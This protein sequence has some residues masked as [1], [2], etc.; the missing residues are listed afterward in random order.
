[1]YMYTRIHTNVYTCIHTCTHKRAHNT[2]MRAHTN[3]RTHMYTYTYAHTE[4]CTQYTYAH[5]HTDTQT[6]TLVNKSFFCCCCCLQCYLA[7]VTTRSHRN[8]EEES[9]FW[10]LGGEESKEQR[11]KDLRKGGLASLWQVSGKGRV[12]R[13]SLDQRQVRSFRAASHKATKTS[14]LMKKKLLTPALLKNTYQRH[15]PC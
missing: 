15:L 13:S 4:T 5:T 10:V 2:H 14:L 7:S 6:P 9:L 8:L 3:V 11:W 12:F 1:M